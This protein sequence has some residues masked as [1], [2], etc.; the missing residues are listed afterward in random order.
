LNCTFVR[1]SNL[2]NTTWGIT[3]NYTSI[4]IKNTGI[5]GVSNFAS[6]S[7]TGNNNA[8]NATIGWGTDNQASLTYADQFEEP[9]S[10]SGTQDYRLKTGAALVDNGA[11]LS[12]SGVTTDIVGTARGATYDIGAWEVA[13]G[14]PDETVTLTGIALTAS[15]GSVTEGIAVAASGSAATSAAGSAAAALGETVAGSAATVAAGTAGSGI[16]AGATGVSGTAAAGSVAGALGALAL[17]V[18]LAASAGTATSGIGMAVTGATAMTVSAGSVAY[19]IGFILTGAASTATGGTLG[20]EGGD[21]TAARSLTGISMTALPGNVRVTGGV[22]WTP[23][24]PRAATI[25][26]AD[27]NTLPPPPRLTGNL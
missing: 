6:V 19:T 22:R 4:T 23:Q 10:A 2:G 15:S 12:G 7:F 16:T 5:F 24:V 14:S 20:T 21:T 8:S 17:G 9:S 25:A 13:S 26:T 1:P 11:D 3:N 18:A 27:G